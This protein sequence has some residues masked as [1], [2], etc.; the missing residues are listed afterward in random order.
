MSIIYVLTSNPCCT[1]QST[2]A[3]NSVSNFHPSL[4]LSSGVVKYQE[5]LFLEIFQENIFLILNIKYFCIEEVL[6]KSYLC[7]NNCSV[8]SGRLGDMIVRL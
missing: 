8:F 5:Y 6:S 4:L 2:N 7:G 3:G 1:S